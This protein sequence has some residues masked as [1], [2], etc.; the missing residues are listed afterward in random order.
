MKKTAKIILIV[1]VSI[2]TLLVVLPYLFRGQIKKAILESTASMIDAKLNFGKVHLSL[3]RNFPNLTVNINEVSLSGIKNFEKDT[4]AFVGKASVTVDIF[5]AIKGQAYEIKSITVRH[6]RIYLKVL[7][8]SSANWNIYHPSED[9][10]APQN[11]T[12]KLKNIAIENAEVIYDDRLL[13]TM[14]KVEEMNNKLSGD[15]TAETTSLK[16][17]TFIKSLTVDYGGV[18]FLNKAECD[19]KADIDANLKDMIFTLKDNEIRINQLYLGIDGNVQMLDEGYGLDLSFSSRQTSFKNLL[20]LVPSIYAK[21]FEKLTAT[22]E[23]KFQGKIKGNYTE[24]SFPAYDIVL[25]VINGKFQYPSLPAAVENV[26]IHAA[27]NNPDGQPDNL[28]IHLDHLHVE[29]AHNPIDM[30]FLLKHPISDPWIKA[31]INGKLDLAQLK[32]IY[33]LG[34]DIKGLINADIS[35]QGNISTLEKGNFENFN[36]KGSIT[37]S[38]LFLPDTSTHND[39]RIPTAQL[40]FSPAYLELS[41]CNVNIG[42]NDIAANGKVSNY[43]GYF[44][45]NTDL[46]ASLNIKSNRLNLNDFM[47]ETSQKPT[48][49]ISI[50]IIEVPKHIDFVVN[51]NLK[52]ILFKQL[53]MN[54]VNG[55]IRVNNQQAILDN[56]SLKTLGG[57]IVVKGSY[58]TINPIQPRVELNLKID[59]INIPKTV[60]TLVTV[61]KIAPLLENIQGFAN[62]SVNLK[63]NLNPDMMPDLNTISSS[64][65]IETGSLKISNIPA[66]QKLDEMLKLNRFKQL[67]T[68]PLSL[69]Y[70]IENGKLNIKPFDIKS[71]NLLG[72]LGGNI[73]IATQELD[74]DF[75]VQ[76]PRSEFGS[77]A[78]SVLDGLVKQANQKGVK[79]KLGETVTLHAKITGQAN[80]PKI[81]TNLVE[82][83]K[84]LANDL[85]KQAEEEFNQKKTEMVQKAQAELEAQKQAAQTKIQQEEASLRQEAEQKKKALEEEAKRK[86]DSLEKKGQEALKKRLKKVF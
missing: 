10:T 7:P 8:D 21:D 84:N 19:L 71:G 25:E 28:S 63:T 43:L 83:S 9:T 20:S 1:L 52:Q 24:T 75:I 30:S 48:D 31:T 32:N 26:A 55:A 42:S 70:L 76:M 81:S 36:A 23:M 5:S 54:D 12:L 41:N 59:N 62:A 60:S 85:K 2:L 80:N 61:Q 45:R 34:I 49:T 35:L 13:N 56:L 86:A 27:V 82:S 66:L 72:T 73:I 46:K 65:N 3:L 51:A 37:V 6:P 64:G 17:L 77:E 78:N 68:G 4:L 39:I 18:R 58:N 29:M 50:G 14:V 33:P 57:L 47:T 22:G 40:D 69:S 11:F 44:L 74:M 79:I 38:D 16:T 15:L 67:E 53:E